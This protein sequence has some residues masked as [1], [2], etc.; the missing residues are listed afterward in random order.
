MPGPF[1]G[2]L[3]N[4]GK[5]MKE[6]Q[7]MQ[8]KM[9]NVEEELAGMEVEASSGGGTVSATVSGAGDVIRVRIRPEAVDPDD[10]EML[11]DLVLTAIREALQK[12]QAI[13][14]E[15]LG[16]VM[17]SMKGMNIPGLPF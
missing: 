5:L 6:A 2:G 16:S 11:E 12:A 13:R 14:E 17:P 9:K 4:I 7:Q 3:P 1:G 8:Q 10:V 15:K